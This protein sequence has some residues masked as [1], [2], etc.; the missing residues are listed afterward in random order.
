M[1]L[2]E[3]EGAAQSKLVFWGVL[4][5]LVNLSTVLL[6]IWLQITE[7]NRQIVLQL[8]RLRTRP[9]APC[10]LTTR[11]TQVLLER[12][13][14]DAEML[15]DGQSL[16]NDIVRLQRA[17]GMQ[18]SAPKLE[19]MLTGMGDDSAAAKLQGALFLKGIEGSPVPSHT[20]S[21]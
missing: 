11:T 5:L 10:A 12:E 20:K 2:T 7:S 8:V 16:R 19:D 6:A 13:I 18:L 1:L 4:L 15:M 14:R 9:L 3:L 17:T 21:L